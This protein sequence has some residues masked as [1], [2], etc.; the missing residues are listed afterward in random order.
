MPGLHGYRFGNEI[1]IQ[2]KAKKAG[3]GVV[4]KN[5]FIYISGRLYCEK[6]HYGG[7]EVTAFGRLNYKNNLKLKILD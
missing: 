7:E 4:L 2:K 5:D 1:Y 3:S 6:I